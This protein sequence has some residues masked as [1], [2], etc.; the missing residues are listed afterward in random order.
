LQDLLHSKALLICHLLHTR[1]KWPNS[2][3]MLL[4]HDACAT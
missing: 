4:A 3:L 2:F 1:G